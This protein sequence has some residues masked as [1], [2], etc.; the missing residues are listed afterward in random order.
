M[1]NNSEILGVNA[2]QAQALATQFRQL[3]LQVKNARKLEPQHVL[4]VATA[5]GDLV[6]LVR[7][8]RGASVHAANVDERYREEFGGYDSYGTVTRRDAASMAARYRTWSEASH[9]NIRAALRSAGLHA[10]QF[11]DEQ[12]TLRALERQAVGAN[13]VL[14]VTQAGAQIAAM[15]VEEGRRL[16][17]LLAA[18]MQMQGNLAAVNTERQA[19]DDADLDRWKRRTR[20]ELRGT[21]I[22]KEEARRR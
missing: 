19:S 2:T 12:T 18:Q 21:P 14:A 11:Y 4:G 13:G 15:Q 9:Q 10:A 17:A 16:R 6:R 1:L 20:P 8:T 5:F 3:E 22:D 7:T